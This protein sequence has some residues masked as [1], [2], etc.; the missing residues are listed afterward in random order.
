MKKKIVIKAKRGV[1]YECYKGFS[2]WSGAR[3]RRG[4]RYALLGDYTD[5]YTVVPVSGMGYSKMIKKEKFASYFVPVNPV[6]CCE[7]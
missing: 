2:D 4:Q 1:T 3:A 6:E 7:E 5:F